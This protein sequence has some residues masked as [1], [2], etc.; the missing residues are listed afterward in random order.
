[1]WRTL[2]GSRMSG[3]EKDILVKAA[4]GRPFQLGMLYD[5]RSDK[6]IPGI[7][8]WEEEEIATIEK[9]LDALKMCSSSYEIVTDDNLNTKSFGLDL[10]SNLA[11]NILGGLVDVS[12]SAKFLLDRTKSSRQARVSLVYKCTTRFEKLPK[13]IFLK[14]SIHKEVIEKQLATHVVTGILYGVDAVFVFDQD[15]KK[16]S[17]VM[18]V[19]SHLQGAVSRIP[20]LTLGG[21]ASAEFSRIKDDKESKFNCTFYGDILLDKNLTTCEEAY[22]VYEKMAEV[23]KVGTEHEKSV[24][25]KVWLMPLTV[26]DSDAARLV[27]E[28]S[29]HLVN[30]TEKLLDDF[31]DVCTEANDLQEY[32]TTLKHGFAGNIPNQLT[33]FSH[34]LNEHIAKYSNKLATLLPEI[35]GNAEKNELELANLLDEM[36]TYP[37]NTEELMG[38]LCEKK[39]EAETLSNLLDK[40]TTMEGK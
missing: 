33:R 29:V 19:R 14:E 38:W 25:K 23:I 2:Y 26:I 32:V 28:I 10:D 21:G 13:D 4:L 30:R 16:K 40:L 9:D 15:A 18:D 8:L 36:N 31:H 27:R 1:M 3:K 24:P 22:G 39:A 11:L 35:R 6:I 37:F 17:N 34:L 5:C 20:K 12:G 7:K